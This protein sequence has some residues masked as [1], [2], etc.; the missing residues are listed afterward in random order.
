MRN[1][2][3]VI[4]LLVQSKAKLEAKDAHHCTP[5]HHAAKKGSYEA[6]AVLLA[7]G[8]NIYA[9]DER[10]WTALHYAAYNG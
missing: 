10:E 7:F 3:P 8:S 6:V 5:L 4:R 2:V 9:N 1:H